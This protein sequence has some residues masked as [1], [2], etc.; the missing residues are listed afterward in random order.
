MPT[1]F[2][3]T[4]KSQCT[5]RFTTIIKESSNID[6][7]LTHARFNNFEGKYNASDCMHQINFCMYVITDEVEFIAKSDS[8]DHVSI[9]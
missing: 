1:A 9:L 2:N 3:C 6:L 4:L 5:K 7:L 8:V